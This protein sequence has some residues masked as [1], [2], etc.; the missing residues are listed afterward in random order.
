MTES[1]KWRADGRGSGHSRGKA[2]DSSS[3]RR[4]KEESV[5]GHAGSGV[6][7]VQLITS[8][9]QVSWL[10]VLAYDLHVDFTMALEHSPL[11]VQA[12]SNG[13]ATLLDRIW[14]IC[15]SASCN[16]YIS[17]NQD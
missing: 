12:A 5:A 1:G 10:P 2:M 17:N 13:M 6:L 15:C 11:S 8:V 16:L 7:E 4:L 9:I 3:Y 14:T